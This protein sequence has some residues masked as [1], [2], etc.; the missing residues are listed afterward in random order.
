MQKFLVRRCGIKGR[1]LCGR[2]C[3]G[4]SEHVA[5]LSKA[6]S[7]APTGAADLGGDPERGEGDKRHWVCF[8]S[9]FARPRHFM[10]RRSLL[11]LA[12][13]LGLSVAGSAVIKSNAPDYL[14]RA[15]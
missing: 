12:I 6:A 4:A 15:Q 13:F 1:G 5:H 2:L 9:F 10:I 11:V 8:P 7:L 14:K 3:V